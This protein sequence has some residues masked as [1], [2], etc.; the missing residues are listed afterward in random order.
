[1]LNQASSSSSTA[2]YGANAQAAQQ[3]DEMLALELVVCLVS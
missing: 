1:M 3:L 2:K